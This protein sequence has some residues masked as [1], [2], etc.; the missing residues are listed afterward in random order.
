MNGVLNTLKPPGMTSHDVVKVVRKIT[1]Q[2]KAGHTGTLDPGAAGVLPVCLGRATRIIQYMQSDKRYRV[3]VT[4]GISTSTQDAFGEVVETGDTAGLTP[5]KVEQ[6]LASMQGRQQQVP[7]MTSAVRYRG[8]RL[9]EL[10]RAGIK[11]VKEP[12]PVQIH[13]INLVDFYYGASGLPKALLDIHCSAGTYIR[14]ICHDLGKK[15]GCGAFMSFLLRTGAGI[16][17]LEKTVT[18]EQ[19]KVLQEKEALNRAVITMSEALAHLTP[20]FVE[21]AAVGAIRSGK[22][23]ILPAYTVGKHLSANQMVRL[24]G[25]AGLIALAVAM[26]IKNSPDHLA[27]QPVKVL[28]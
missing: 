2:K 8:K 21:G 25:P 13:A 9:Y 3:E 24:E 11:V 14:T 17:S 19:L 23:V 1:G 18:L 6:C 16:F 10:A 27:F 28:V 12:R 7:P 20:V 26:Y 4:F 22:R 5:G 15:L